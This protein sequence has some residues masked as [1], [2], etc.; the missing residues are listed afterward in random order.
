MVQMK[1]KEIKKR[2]KSEFVY[3]FSMLNIFEKPKIKMF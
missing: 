2:E 1:H 3:I